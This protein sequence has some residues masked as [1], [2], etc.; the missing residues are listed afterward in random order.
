MSKRLTGIDERKNVRT[1]RKLPGTK[2]NKDTVNRALRRASDDRCAIVER[3]LEVLGSA[4]LTPR[5][6]AWP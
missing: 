6:R 3:Q 5:E 1:A 4:E 2:T